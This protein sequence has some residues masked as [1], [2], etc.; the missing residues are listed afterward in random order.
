MMVV[1]VI[2]FFILFF[3]NVAV[4]ALNSATEETFGHLDWIWRA[5]KGELNLAGRI[6][7]MVLATIVTLPTIIITLVGKGLLLLICGICA[8]F[9]WIFRDRSKDKKEILP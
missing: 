5:T 1:W 7:C 6:I 2:L 4:G 9:Y 3:V 8:V